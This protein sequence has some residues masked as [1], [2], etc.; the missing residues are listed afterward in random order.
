MQSLSHF[1]IFIANIL[2]KRYIFL[3]LRNN[4]VLLHFHFMDLSKNTGIFKGLNTRII[5]YFIAFA[6]SPLLIFSILG[7]ILNKDMLTRINLNKLHAVNRR[8]CE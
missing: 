7:Y 5:T 2:K 3:N 4:R 1:Y 6:F 8:L